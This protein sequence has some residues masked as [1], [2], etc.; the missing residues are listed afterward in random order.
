[1]AGDESAREIVRADPRWRMRMVVLLVVLALGM[2]ICYWYFFGR[3]GTAIAAGDLDGALERL[4]Q[5]RRLT[6]ALVGVAIAAAAYFLAVAV[7]VLRSGRFPPPGAR[8]VRDT[9]VRRGTAARAIAV[10]SVLLSLLLPA[11][12]VAVHM[13]MSRLLG[14]LVP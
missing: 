9:P 5:V 7:R 11:T 3:V 10:L 8:V 2:A 1:M 13:L 12:A 14:S 6:L 4:R